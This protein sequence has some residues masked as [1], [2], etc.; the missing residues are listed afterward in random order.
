MQR[1]LLN[2]KPDAVSRNLVGEICRRIE[3]AGFRIVAMEKTRL[4]RCEAEFF[5]HVHR[6]KSFF[7]DLIQFMVSGPSV[8][9]VVEGENVIQN[10]RVLIGST[11]PSE[12]A[13]GTIRRDM[14]ENVTRNCVH[15]SDSEETASRE[16][17]FF[18]STRRLL[19]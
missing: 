2:I 18:F 14:A 1:T 8:P 17:A 5:Y 9:M 16:I 7:E 13:E 6:D 15:A 4:T 3:A 19:D 12:A 10:L 11:D